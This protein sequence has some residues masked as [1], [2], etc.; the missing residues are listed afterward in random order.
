MSSLHHTCTYRWR[1][2]NRPPA[3]HCPGQ[4]RWPGTK[5]GTSSQVQDHVVC[6][7]HS[8]VDLGAESDLF[9]IQPHH[10]KPAFFLSSSNFIK[11]L[12]RVGTWLP[13]IPKLFITQVQFFLNGGRDPEKSLLNP[14]P[15]LRHLGA[16]LLIWARVAVKHRT[17]RL[18]YRY[19]LGTI[20]GIF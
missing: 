6:R 15:Q 5:A 13:T 10:S 4:S 2:L 11:L 16:F 3:A 7:G 17:C 8:L 18:Y 20:G 19:G 14:D 12:Q 9:R 1:S